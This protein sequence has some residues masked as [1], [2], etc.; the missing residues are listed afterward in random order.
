MALWHPI[1]PTRP[2]AAAAALTQVGAETVVWLNEAQHYLFL[3][4]DHRLGEQIAAGLRVLL[5][6]LHPPP[7]ARAGHHV[8]AVL[9]YPHQRS[10]ARSA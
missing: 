5:H 1:A 10:G 6:D 9:G 3:P 7:G 8:A 2:K 4:H